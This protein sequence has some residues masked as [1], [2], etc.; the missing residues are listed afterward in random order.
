MQNIIWRILLVSCILGSDAKAQTYSKETVLIETNYGNI[1]LKLFEET[2]L[3][4]K[5]FLDLIRKHH[6]D[7]L[8]FHRVINNFM[9]QGGDPLSKNAKPGDS[10][11][12]GD[13]GYMVPAEFRDNIIHKKGRLC[14]AREGD[15]INPKRE[16]SASQFY[17]VMGKVRTIEELNEYEKKRRD[18]EKKNALNRVLSREK[19]KDIAKS[20]ERL[21]IE[22]KTDSLEMEM[23]KIV[24]EVDEEYRKTHEFAFSPLQIKTYTTVGGTP[25]LDGAYT[26]FGE[27]IEGQDV[28]DSIANVA[29]DKRDRPIEDVRMKIS[30]VE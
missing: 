22:N 14:A 5:N 19:N 29:K 7:S 4:K 2:P 30:I 18:R 15:D 28:V 20:V 24:A 13:I 23:K 10:L 16:S 26:V 1:K 6:Y 11:G 17:I 12:H 27:V 9:I 25:H 3:H 8:L 21:R